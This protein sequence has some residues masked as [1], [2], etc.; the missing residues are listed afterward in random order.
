MRKI[1]PLS[2]RLN[3]NVGPICNR[4]VVVFSQQIGLISQDSTATDADFLNRLGRSAPRL[5]S[6][7]QNPKLFRCALNSSGQRHLTPSP[8]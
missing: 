1:T 8:S 3:S 4:F 6:A 5:R 7:F 2:R